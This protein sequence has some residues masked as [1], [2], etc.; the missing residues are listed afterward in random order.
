VVLTLC[1]CQ[2]K[3]KESPP[4]AP[5]VVEVRDATSAVIAQL[6]PG[7]PCRATIGPVELIVGGPPL[8]AQHGED[9]W[10]GEVATNG[11]T[12]LRGSE[13]I[14]RLFPVGDSHAEAVLGVDGIAL[15]RIT[16]TATEAMVSNGGGTLLRRLSLTTPSTIT[17]DA[18][19]LS[20]SGTTD[21]VLAALISAPELVPEVRMLSACERVLAKG[22]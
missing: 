2:G 15:A 12:L 20:V 22:S 19:K 8:V 1:G 5:S 4:P 7:H 9:H 17:I 16:A 21:L 18:P 10:T 14:A 3:A 13:R 11:I 6:R